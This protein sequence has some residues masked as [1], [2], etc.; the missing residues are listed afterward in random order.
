MQEIVS[1][2][3]KAKAEHGKEKAVS[4]ISQDAGARGGAILVVWTCSF[5]PV[6]M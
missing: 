6:Q 5:S 4:P 2:L 1:R 3:S